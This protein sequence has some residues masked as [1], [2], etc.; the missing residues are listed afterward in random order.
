MIGATLG[1]I[2][3]TYQNRDLIPSKY[4]LRVGGYTSVRLPVPSMSF[5]TPPTAT[6]ASYNFESE[7]MRVCQEDSGNKAYCACSADLLRDMDVWDDGRAEY[8]YTEVKES[9]YVLC[10]VDA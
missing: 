3:L 5:F 9:L 8:L 6:P 4:T 2:M 7:F 10:L 1:L